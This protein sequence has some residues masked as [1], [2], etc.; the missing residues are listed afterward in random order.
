MR[1]ALRH[2]LRLGS[3][4]GGVQLTATEPDDKIGASTVLQGTAQK[5]KDLCQ[6]WHESCNIEALVC[7]DLGR[8]RYLFVLRTLRSAFWGQNDIV[9][10]RR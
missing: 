2:E 1:V 4:C 6:I 8:L 5:A 3:Q 10:P 7:H 9:Q